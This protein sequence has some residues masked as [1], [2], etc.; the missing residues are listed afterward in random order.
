MSAG[1]L[2]LQV[3]QELT[4]ACKLLTKHPHQP[5]LPQGC[6]ISWADIA[7]ATAVNKCTEALHKTLRG[8]GSLSGAAGSPMRE[9]AGIRPRLLISFMPQTKLLLGEH[10]GLITWAQV[11]VQQY[12]PAG[13]STLHGSAASQSWAPL[14]RLWVEMIMCCTGVVD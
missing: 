5:L 2:A 7:L 3:G 8:G 1:L 6:G 12:W 10:P 14:W 4:A 13:I 9:A 11:T